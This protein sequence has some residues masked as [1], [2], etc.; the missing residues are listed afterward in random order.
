MNGSP[1][2][3]QFSPEQGFN[4]N[5]SDYRAGGLMR[6]GLGINLGPLIHPFFWVANDLKKVRFLARLQRNRSDTAWFPPAK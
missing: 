2:T 1:S 5:R 3:R 6:K 4:Q